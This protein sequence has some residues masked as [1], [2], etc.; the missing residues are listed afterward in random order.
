MFGG[1]FAAQVASRVRL[2]LAAPNTFSVDNLG[3][4]V[5][6][7]VIDVIGQRRTIRERPLVG[8]AHAFVFWGFVA[9]AGY[10][11]VEFLRGLGIVDLTA[12][13]A[14][15]VY[16]V[17]LTPSACAVLAGILLLLIRRGVVRPV[18]LGT[19]VSVES[20]VIAL[21]I[22]TLMVTFLLSWRLDE[23][24]TADRKSTRLNSSHIQKSR[25]P[26]SA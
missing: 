15:Y 18:A 20:V 10:T 2:V 4:R 12:T 22:A 14:F 25:M 17:V 3:F 16:R 7:F 11:A 1:V 23:A 13:S 6:R 26:S 9:F 8:V 5:G 19:S 24:S 21:F